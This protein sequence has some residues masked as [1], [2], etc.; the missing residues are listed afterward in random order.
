MDQP[1]HGAGLPPPSQARGAAL[2]RSEWLALLAALVIAHLFYWRIVRYPSEYD[3]QVYLEIGDDIGRD[4]LFSHYDYSH[5]RTYAYPLL[6]SVL[7]RAAGALGLP[8]VFVVFEV[9]LALFLL[10]AAFFRRRLAESWPAFAPWAFAAIVL[11]PFALSYAPETLTESTTLSLILSCGGCWLALFARR[12][13]PWRSVLAGSLAMGLAVMVRPANLF[14]L[15]AWVLAVAA[16]CLVRRPRAREWIPVAGVLAAGCALPMVPQYVNNVRYFGRHTPLIVVSLGQNQQYWGIKSLKYAT[17]V[18]S[19]T[20]K[21]H[22][23]VFYGNPFAKGTTYDRE[24]PM[25]WYLENP[26]R[27]ALTLGLHVFNMLDQDVLFTYSRDLDPWYR[28]PLGL[29]NHA[30]IALALIGG[31]MLALR[32]RRE[33]HY[34]PAAIALWGLVLAHVGLHATTLVEMRFGLPLL[35][36]AGPTAAGAVRELASRQ[37]WRPFIVA[38]AFVAVWTTGSLMLSHWVRQQAPL[39]REFEK[40]EDAFHGQREPGIKAPKAPARSGTAVERGRPPQRNK[41]KNGR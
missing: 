41:Q 4:G 27:G 15:A 12:G 5:I 28:V 39:V 32:A 1:Q 17:M 18:F 26:G 36:V 24:R 6:L 30:T 31:G 29:L 23:R 8:V 34:L 37:S 7:S 3:A 38:G 19:T 11:N 9:Q 10:A 33:R 22:P 40:G 16:V 20:Y 14:A 21:E 35:L 2:R 13:P 25:A